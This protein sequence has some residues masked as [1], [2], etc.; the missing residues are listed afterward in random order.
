MINY[1]YKQKTEF[2]FNVVKHSNRKAI[3]ELLPK[4]IH[5]ESYDLGLANQAKIKEIRVEVLSEFIKKLKSDCLEV[6]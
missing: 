3:I 5:I 6:I 4:L 2:L 1:I